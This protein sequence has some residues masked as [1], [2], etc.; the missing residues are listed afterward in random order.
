[1]PA[2]ARGQHPGRIAVIAR[3]P[4]ALLQGGIGLLRALLAT[5]AEVA[6]MAPGLDGG[7]GL[8]E[9]LGEPA[10]R[11]HLETFAF[12]K[13]ALRG[14]PPE[15]TLPQLVERWRPDA[16]FASGRG[17]ALLGV[18]AARAS[19][20]RR[21]VM[22][23]DDLA[24]VEAGAGEGRRTWLAGELQRRRRAQALRA[25]DLVVFRSDADRN[26]LLADRSLV[27]DQPSL[28]LPGPGIDLGAFPEAPLPPI[29]G[30]LAFLMPVS[31]AEPA[32]IATYVA[33]ARIVRARAP[34]IRLAIGLD[35]TAG[36]SRAA[37]LE[38]AAHGESGLVTFLGP[39]RDLR[40]WRP[41][42][43][44]AHAVV[45]WGEGADICG[46]LSAAMSLGR[47][48]ILPTEANTWPALRDGEN[49]IA[50]RAATPEGL[51][52]GMLALL[53]RPD[54]IP[55]MARASRARA[56]AML[57]ERRLAQRLLA[58]AGIGQAA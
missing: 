8:D 44:A 33:A 34:G 51:A 52:D 9:R 4:D 32:A 20:A 22:L 41:A 42:I 49:G 50:A 30:G 28:V 48:V 10:A 25:A 57:D 39:H 35:G 6:A 38:P 17:T 19:G 45:H 54:L 24:M 16:V 29:A 56:V 37:V 55:R 11:L 53:K 12:D 3:D 26:W 2:N 47:P 46:V 21:V 7:L 36:R 14:S 13:P 15:P 58:A 5:G 31:G 18:K 40:D 27:D 43:A 23:L 1:M